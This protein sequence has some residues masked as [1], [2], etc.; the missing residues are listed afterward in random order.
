MVKFSKFVPE[1]Y[2][3]TPIDVVVLKCCKN[4]SNGKSLKSGVIYRTKKFQLPLNVLLLHGS[5]PKSARA[6]PTHLAR[7]VPNFIQ[8]GSLS[9]EL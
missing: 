7:N 6:S 3:A 4:F 5:H 2:M 9:A 8:I 1:V